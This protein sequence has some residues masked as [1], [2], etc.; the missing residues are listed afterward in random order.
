MKHDILAAQLELL[1]NRVPFAWA[2]VTEI[3]GSSSAKPGAK[4]IFDVNGKL[5]AGWIGGGCVQAMAAQA[6][7]S[8][9]TKG[10]PEMVDID[11]NDEF[12]GAGMPCGGQMRVYVEPVLPKPVLWLAGNGLIVD[13]LSTFAHTVG[14][15]VTVVDNKAEANHLTCVSRYITEDGRYEKL[16]PTADD[17]VVIAT[18]HFG[19]Y[20]AL[21]QALNSPAEYVALVSSRN[22]ADLIKRRLA[23][24]GFSETALA[25]LHAPAGLNLGAKTPEEIALSI[26]SQMVQV[27]R[28]AQDQKS[29]A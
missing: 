22:R 26:I 1:Q 28:D 21:V 5:L 27:R 6:A 7:I 29:Q 10:K 18:H 24:E 8:S 15:E 14:F 25:R 2:V 23:Q 4:A 9:L 13:T 3:S 16:T 11:L 17:Y 12:F 19:D 20:L